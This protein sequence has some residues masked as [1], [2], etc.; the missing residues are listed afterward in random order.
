[1]PHRVV[2]ALRLLIVVATPAVLVG[3][4]LWVLANPAFVRAQYSLT[5]APAEVQGLGERAA[6]D[7]G[8]DGVRAIHPL[9]EG[10]G[11]LERARLDD[12]REAFTAA[13]VEHMRDVREVTTATFW[14][15]GIALFAGLAAAVGL[16]R[17]V[18]ARAIAR[19]L[20]GGARFTLI[21]ALALGL[22]MA[23]SF[24]AAFAAFHGV[25]F[26]GDSWRF[27]ADSTLLKLYPEYFWGLAAAAAAAVITLQAVAVELLTRRWAKRRAHMPSAARART[28]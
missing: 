5:A 28:A 19:A 18:G 17:A 15:W 26:T 8:V 16:R 22:A 6:R 11:L 12:G 4:A 25:F 1:M 27:P 14:V 2:I 21:A 20:A 10:V 9:G 13:E 3:N 7:L 23:L 24:D